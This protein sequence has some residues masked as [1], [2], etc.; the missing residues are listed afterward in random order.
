MIIKSNFFQLIQFF[1]Q[2]KNH[3]INEKMIKIFFD[4]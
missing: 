3:K 1:G 2:I 4:W